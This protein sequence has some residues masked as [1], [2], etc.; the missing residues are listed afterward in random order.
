MADAGIVAKPSQKRTAEIFPKRKS[1]P[2]KK[3][4]GWGHPHFSFFLIYRLRYSPQFTRQEVIRRPR[5]THRHFAVLQ[6]L[7]GAGITILIFFNGFGVNQVGNVYQHSVGI[8]PFTTDLFLERVEEPVNLNGKRLS[9]GLAFAIS[10][11]FF[12]ELG[13]VFAAN[14]L[15]NNDVLKLLQ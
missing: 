9:F 5:T 8:N 6:L 12:S 14:R 1:P 11:G 4:V 13:E 7:D 3:H 10:H 2:Y 15:R